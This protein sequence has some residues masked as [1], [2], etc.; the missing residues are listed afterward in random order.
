[1]TQFVARTW[2][3]IRPRNWCAVS[4]GRL[5]AAAVFG[6]I[7][8]TPV[9]QAQTMAVTNAAASATQ[10]SNDDLSKEAENPVTLKITLPLRYEAE[11]NDGAYRATKST[12]ELDQAVVPFRL[13]DDWAL[14]T[15]TKLPDYAQPPKKL[16]DHWE[17]GLSNG[18]TTFFLS[19]AKGNGFYWGAGPVLYYP[20]ATNAA[21][22]VNKWGSGPSVAF[23]FKNSDSPWVFG[24][25]A[26]NIW[27]FGGPP[28]SSDRTNSLLINPFVSYHFGDGWSVGS[29]P[30]IAANWL[31]KAGQVWTIPVGGGVSRTFRL[32]NQPMKAAID[33]YYNAIRPQASFETWFLEVTLTFLFAT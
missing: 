8:L 16:G 7:F 12:F 31:S 14:I 4:V 33:C 11:F 10:A 25:V 24:A 28:G 1:M 30:N 17:S 5:T 13:S 32:G 20:T 15:R 22:G 18:Y 27:S 23:V 2:S 26:N 3:K 29:S 9:V 19:P 21:L 6:L